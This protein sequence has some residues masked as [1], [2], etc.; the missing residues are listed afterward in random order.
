MPNM[1]LST[2]FAVGFYTTVQRCCG[3][4]EHVNW[5]PEGTRALNGSEVA[6]IV[7]AA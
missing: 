3:N 4:N 5:V 2:V 1:I 6:V 7:S